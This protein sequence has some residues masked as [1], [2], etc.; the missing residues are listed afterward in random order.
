MEERPEERQEADPEEQ[1]PSRCV[2]R[3]SRAIRVHQAQPMSLPRIVIRRP[4]EVEGEEITAGK[5]PEDEHSRHRRH[6]HHRKDQGED[7]P[8][9]HRSRSRVEPHGGRREMGPVRHENGPPQV[10]IV[11]GKVVAA[12]EEDGARDPAQHAA[13]EE[14]VEDGAYEHRAG[15]RFRAC[16]DGVRYGGIHTSTVARRVRKPGRPRVWADSAVRRES[17]WGG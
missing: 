3:A 13:D 5:I 10:G 4:H 17:P 16:G 6:R 7:G 8:V 14:V 15:R 2:Q 9:P 1:A 12:E 11:V